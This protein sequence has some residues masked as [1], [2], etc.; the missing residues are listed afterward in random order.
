MSSFWTRSRRVSDAPYNTSHVV[1]YFLIRLISISSPLPA[2]TISFPFYNPIIYDP[3]SM[4]QQP[5]DSH[6]APSDINENAQSNTVVDDRSTSTSPDPFVNDVS[7][8]I[9]KPKTTAEL[10][11]ARALKRTERRTAQH[12]KA[13]SHRQAV[14]GL[15]ISHDQS[16]TGA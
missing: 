16:P 11:A 2:L 6:S 7:V 3:T 5:Q 10:V 13:E 8:V 12:E 4:S 14:R 15:S 9:S 1:F